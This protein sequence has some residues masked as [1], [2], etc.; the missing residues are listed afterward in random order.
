MR[1]GF[2]IV[3]AMLLVL[4]LLGAWFA[5]VQYLDAQASYAKIAF[6][7]EFFGGDSWDVCADAAISVINWATTTVILGALSAIGLILLIYGAASKKP[8]AA[9]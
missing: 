5:S 7:C 1:L 6:Y 9:P 3:G 4:G 8:E 2:V